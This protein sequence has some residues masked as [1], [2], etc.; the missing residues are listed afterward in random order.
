M[1]TDNA[2]GAGFVFAFLA[3]VG[4]LLIVGGAIFALA[5]GGTTRRPDP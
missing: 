1:F 5:G 4:G 3:P 2:L